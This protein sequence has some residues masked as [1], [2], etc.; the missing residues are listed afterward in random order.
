MSGLAIAGELAGSL[1]SSAAGFISAERQMNFQERMSN[2]SHQREVNDLKRAGLNPILSAGGNGAQTPSGAMFTPDNPAR[3]IAQTVIAKQ[4]ARA[5]IELLK[6][7]TANSAAQAAKALQETENLKTLEPDRIRQLA[8]AAQQQAN[9]NA[10]QAEKLTEE[11]LDLKLGHAEKEA[12]RKFWNSSVAQAMPILER[13]LKAL[14]V[15]SRYTPNIHIR[16]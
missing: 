12:Y 8:A 11:I 3:G 1:A 14:E 4:T 16:K 7:Q 15:I 2:T 10:A 9:V 5:Q 6:A 13:I